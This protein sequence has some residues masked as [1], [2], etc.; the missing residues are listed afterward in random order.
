MSRA[1]S[2]S[3]RHAKRHKSA[4]EGAAGLRGS[5]P[6][7]AATGLDPG[8]RDCRRI[9]TQAALLQYHAVPPAEATAPLLTTPG[10]VC[11]LA[12][13]LRLTIT[14]S[15][16][17]FGSQ[18]TEIPTI[19]HFNSRPRPSLLAHLPRTTPNRLMAEIGNRIGCDDRESSVSEAGT[20]ASDDGYDSRGSSG[21]T[22]YADESPPVHPHCVLSPFPPASPRR[23]RS[24]TSHMPY[25]DPA[26][27]CP[28]SKKV[29]AGIGH[30][31]R[32]RKMATQAESHDVRS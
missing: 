21:G 20:A 30:L 1:A 16:A 6:S 23:S 13:L 31:K 17:S 10:F 9:S 5:P 24:P 11:A 19:E 18:R 4:S 32:S 29:N 27:G 2:G 7:P 8:T 12:C 26:A 22:R 25:I 3:A 15:I 14:S 28:S